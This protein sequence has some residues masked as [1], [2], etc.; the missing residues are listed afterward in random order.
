MLSIIS[1]AKSL[2]LETTSPTEQGTEPAFPSHFKELLQLCKSLSKKQIKELMH[3]IP[4]AII[5]A[6]DYNR[7]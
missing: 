3:I 5:N 4:I 2:D 1:S 7:F 6:A